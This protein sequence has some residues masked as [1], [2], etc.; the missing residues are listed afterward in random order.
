MSNFPYPR[1]LD[2]VQNQDW[3]ITPGAYH[4]ILTALDNHAQGFTISAE[5]RAAI[6]DKQKQSTL[7]ISSN[8][9]AVMSI[10]GI[11]G[12]RL[13]W[14]DTACGGVDV[15]A[16]VGTAQQLA[17]DPAVSTIIMDWNSPGGTVTGVP[18]AYD[19]LKAVGSKKLLI[20]YTD[21]QQC[22]AAQWLASAA[23]SQYAAASA[24][25][26]SVGVYNLILDRSKQLADD[27]VKVEAISAGKHKLMGASFQ[28]LSDEHRAMLQ[29]RV[30]SIHADFKKAVT[31]HRTV[32]PSAMEGQA[33]TGKQ[34]V[35]AGMIDGIY[36]S[37]SALISALG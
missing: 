18:E 35:K 4:A 3:C 36:P 33:L 1:I 7:S 24:C 25:V 12:K 28:P 9:V 6:Q 32:D 22:S 17:S 20:S 29:D 21:T 34:G 5:E 30:D 16:I 15:N 26:A 11:I 13:D 14:M 10:S 23:R 37:I 19:A 31:R 8:G 27:G 2:M